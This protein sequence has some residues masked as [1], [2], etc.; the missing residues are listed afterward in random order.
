MQKNIYL[1]IFS[2]IFL[3]TSCGP[4]A[5]SI[6]DNRSN[7]VLQEVFQFEHESFQAF[8]D[9]LNSLC[10]QTFEGRQV[11]MQ[12]GRESW[13][14]KRMIMKV[15]MCMPN[16][17]QVPFH[18]DEDQSRTWMFLNEEGQLRFRHDHRHEDGTPEEITLYGGYAD[19]ERGT[20]YRQV[21]PADE[22]TIDLLTRGVGSE[23]VV[24]MNEEMTVFSYELHYQ[25]ELL[26]RAAFD[27]TRPI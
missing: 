27:L 14:D 20:A 26:F 9:N 2:G 15:D 25:G 21:F 18:L 11:Y 7:E 3:F 8:F 22:Y 13:E 1:L 16:V 6:E 5:G 19:A 12:E 4:G 24:E 17:I 10:G 23:W